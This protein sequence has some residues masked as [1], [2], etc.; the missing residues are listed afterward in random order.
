MKRRRRWVVFALGTLAIVLVAL[1]IAATMLVPALH[2]TVFNPF[3]TERFD[4]AK[5]LAAES[6]PDWDYRNPRGPMAED[7]RRGYLHK[8]MRKAE[9]RALLGKVNNNEVEERAGDADHY[10]LGAWGR[11]SIDGDYLIVHY[12]KS[13]KLTSTEIYTH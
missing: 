1:A 11:M 8:G 3:A 5:W 10:Y 7:L 12:D 6:S 4:R 13:G 2:D 9:V